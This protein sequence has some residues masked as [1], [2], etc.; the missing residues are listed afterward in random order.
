MAEGGGAGEY[1]STNVTLCTEDGLKICN[2]SERDRQSYKDTESGRESWKRLSSSK[3]PFLFFVYVDATS[4][5]YLNCVSAILL[6]G[7]T[8]LLHIS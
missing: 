2:E 6:L 8:F 1:G 5:E 7:S 4:K 3:P